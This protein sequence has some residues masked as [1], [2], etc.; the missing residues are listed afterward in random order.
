MQATHLFDDMPDD[1]AFDAAPSSA[2]RAALH[3]FEAAGLGKA[4]FTCYRVDDL[5]GRCALCS[6]KLKYRF[7]VRG[8]DGAECVV[9]SECVLK[10]AAEL[11]G[12]KEQRTQ[13]E[14][15]LRE[16]QAQA[17]QQAKLAKVERLFAEWKADNGPLLEWMESKRHTFNF[18][19]SLLQAVVQYGALTPG[20]QAAAERCMAQDKARTEQRVAAHV[21]TVAAAPVVDIAAIER[22]FAKAMDNG[23]R[24]PKLRLG[25][26][27]FKPAKSHS[28]NPGAVYVTTR[29][30]KGIDAEGRYLGK[31]MGGKFLKV[32]ECDA[33]SEQAVVNVCAQPADAAVAYGKRYGEC[34]VCGRELTDGT[35]IDRGIGPVCAEKYGF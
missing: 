19:A 21:Q 31:V 15:R 23:V 12:F 17:R 29:P 35:S 16:Q 6:T 7:H 28:T 5:G 3:P 11:L 32:R 8:T 26:F 27:V 25:E 10:T 20:Q 9:G 1:L 18:A 4:P 30:Q 24:N 14:R 2:P 22:A 33:T 13:L 34:A